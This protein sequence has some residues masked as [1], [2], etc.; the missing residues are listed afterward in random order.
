ML[1]LANLY[2]TRWQ[3]ITRKTGAGL[4]TLLCSAR[5]LLWTSDAFL[6]L[7]DIIDDRLRFYDL[8]YDQ[9]VNRFYPIISL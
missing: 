8:D 2:P 9:T 3:D 7:V 4:G 1:R 6:R 5:Y